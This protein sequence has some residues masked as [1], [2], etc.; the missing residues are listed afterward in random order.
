MRKPAKSEL[1]LLVLFGAAVFLALNLFGVRA[2]MGRR[3]AIA[4]NIAQTRTSLEEAKSWIIA[5]ESI[6][7]AHE[8]MKEHPA[9][10][11]T[12]DGASTAL[13]NA[14]RAEAEKAGIKVVEETLLPSVTGSAGSSA[15]L[16]TKLSGPF[17]G[18]ARFLFELQSPITWRAVTKMT[19]RSDTEPPNVVM[20]MEIRQYY[21][22]PTKGGESTGS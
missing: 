5:A 22:P 8:W 9:P 4:S 2:W 7:A 3:Q 10:V 21:V 13:L 19:I 6:Q 14:V 16:Q 11:N 1:R 20:D 17:A 18:V 12:G 15:L